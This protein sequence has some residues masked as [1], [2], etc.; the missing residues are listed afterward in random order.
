[1]ETAR[2]DYIIFALFM[3]VAVFFCFRIFKSVKGRKKPSKSSFFSYWF[4]EIINGSDNDHPH[5]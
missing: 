5:Y 2:M 1:L 4:W 3:L